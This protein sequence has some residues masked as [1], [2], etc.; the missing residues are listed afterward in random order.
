MNL[1]NFY[2]KI[3]NLAVV[4]LCLIV[5]LTPSKGLSSD[6]YFVSILF[7]VKTNTAKRSHPSCDHLFN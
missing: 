5:Q 1:S 6:G 7:S 2:L 3:I 4:S